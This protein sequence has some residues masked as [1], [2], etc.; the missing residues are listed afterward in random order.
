MAIVP[1]AAQRHDNV[2]WK[3]Y[4]AHIEEEE[5]TP[6][7]HWV[8]CDDLLR[9][10]GGRIG[11]PGAPAR[12]YAKEQLAGYLDDLAFACGYALGVEVQAGFEIAVL[13]R[14]LNQHHPCRVARSGFFHQH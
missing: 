5:S 2:A 12:R 13:C 8:M 10:F 4:M 6:T 11:T 14:A 9:S 7:P 3:S 1:Q